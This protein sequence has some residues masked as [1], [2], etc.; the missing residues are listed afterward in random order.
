MDIMIRGN[1]LGT[2]NPLTIGIVAEHQSFLCRA[3]N[4]D[5]IYRYDCIG[6]TES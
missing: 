1:I 4:L 6:L 2:T 3:I 5:K